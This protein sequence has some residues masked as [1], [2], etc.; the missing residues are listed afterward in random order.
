M[1]LLIALACAGRIDCTA[2]D[3]D[4]CAEAPQC[5]VLSG[6]PVDWTEDGACYVGD[7]EPQGC[8]DADLACPP[9]LAYGAAPDADDAC[10]EFAS[11][12]LPAGWT[13]CDADL[14]SVGS[15]G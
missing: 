14:G 8:Q 5:A 12:C 10:F 4:A 3:T 1:I 15:C 6:G 9:A 13:A 7:A 11:G 2:L